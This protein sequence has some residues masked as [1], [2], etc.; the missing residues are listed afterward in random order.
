MTI[1][2][3]EAVIDMAKAETPEDHRLREA[4]EIYDIAN[5][6]NIPIMTAIRQIADRLEMRKS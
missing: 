6:H 2:M 1:P 4:T 5:D 3:A